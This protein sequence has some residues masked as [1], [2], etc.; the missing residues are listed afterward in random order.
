[1]IYDSHGVENIKPS[2]SSKGQS[3]VMYSKLTDR[4]YFLFKWMVGAPPHPNKFSATTLF[5]FN[6]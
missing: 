4:K 6:K 3:L 5:G 1:M 2:Y